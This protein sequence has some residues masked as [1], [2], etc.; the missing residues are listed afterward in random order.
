MKLQKKENG[1]LACGN[2]GDSVELKHFAN[3]IFA[4]CGTCN[5]KSQLKEVD[6][7]RTWN[8]LDCGQFV[9][10][11]TYPYHNADHSLQQLT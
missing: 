10:E 11:S 7:S 6:N 9:T 5:E 1:Y 8:C 3:K 4:Q 2:C